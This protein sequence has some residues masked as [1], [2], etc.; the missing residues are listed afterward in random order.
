MRTPSSQTPKLVIMPV[1]RTRDYDMY[2]IQK[3]VLFSWHIEPDILAE[4][5]MTGAY[6]EL[7]STV[8]NVNCFKGSLLYMGNV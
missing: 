7:L 3:K 4:L 2:V 1:K 8:L 6:P 5:L